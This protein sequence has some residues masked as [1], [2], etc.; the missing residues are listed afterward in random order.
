[1]IIVRFNP[2]PY[3]QNSGSVDRHTF[4]SSPGSNWSLSTSSHIWRPPTDVYENEE[5]FVIRIEIAGMRESDFQI[6]ISENVL[7]IS[8]VRNDSAEERRAYHQM[9]IHYGEFL[10]E[11][12][13]TAPIDLDKVTAEYQNGLLYV[14]VP[15]TQPKQIAIT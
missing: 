9:E 14:Y 11:F 13:F 4:F 3:R 5:R 12:V 8:G 15:K 10:T 6:N 2:N 7:S 1:M